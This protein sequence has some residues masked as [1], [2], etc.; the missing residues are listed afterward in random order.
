MSPG[1]LQRQLYE[2]GL[3]DPAE[4]LDLEERYGLSPSAPDEAPEALPE[5]PG[6]R[7][8]PP[9]FGLP[10]TLRNPAT[11]RAGARPEPGDTVEL[12]LPPIADP[13]R[14]QVVL[15]VRRGQSWSVVSPAHPDQLHRLDL[16]TRTTPE[17]LLLELVV[18][19][20]RGRWAVA[21]PPLDLPIAWSRP[22]K[23]RWQALREALERGE[24][25]IASVELSHPPGS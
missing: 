23:Q 5:P 1:S 17:G 2:R 25:P 4:A 14:R 19:A 18:P 13:D 3:L 21:L 15:M 24:A 16:S 9:G 12:Q 8:P 11:L 7:I 22:P 10:T 20:S 6:W